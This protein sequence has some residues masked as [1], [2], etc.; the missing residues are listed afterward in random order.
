M[1]R[2]LTRMSKGRNAFIVFCAFYFAIF[3]IF[4]SGCSL[5]GNG[6]SLGVAA[7]GTNTTQLNQ[8]IEANVLAEVSSVFGSSAAHMTQVQRNALQDG[9]LADADAKCSSYVN[10]LGQSQKA[11]DAPIGTLESI[12]GGVGA[13][14]TDVTVAR[15]LAGSASILKSGRGEFDQD[16]F[17]DTVMN[18]IING[19]DTR[20][21]RL[22]RT[23]LTNQTRALSGYGTRRAIGDALQYHHACSLMSGLCSRPTTHSPSGN[24][25][26]QK[27]RPICRRMMNLPST[28]QECQKECQTNS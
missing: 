24:M 14:V 9:L 8:T 5:L 4:G 26:F 22:K 12:L 16:R 19:M 1:T 25:P 13:I 18:V 10:S 3:A 2:T 27:S 11:V 28:L 23:I 17:A 6:S 7:G 20:R 21:E 15:S